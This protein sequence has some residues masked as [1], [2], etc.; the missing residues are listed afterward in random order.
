MKIHILAGDLRYF[1]TKALLYPFLLNR[2]FLA[3]CDIYYEIFSRS[4][5][6]IKDCDIVIIDS[7]VFRNLWGSDPN[8]AH[9]S[10]SAEQLNDAK[11]NTCHTLLPFNS[12]K[13]F[14]G[15]QCEQCH[16]AGK[17]YHKDYVMRDKELAR[18]VGLIVPKAAH[19]QGCH[20]ADS[21]NIKPFDFDELWLRIT[22]GPKHKKEDKSAHIKP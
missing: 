22:H 5:D 19:C 13:R 20:T 17:V 2:E 21:P 8:K 4:L 14:Q 6:Q 7:K 9:E 1:N 10:L 18:A 12:D 15:V 11:C 3:D 16:G